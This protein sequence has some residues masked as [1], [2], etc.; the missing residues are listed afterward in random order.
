MKVCPAC[1]EENPE[2]ARFCLNCGTALQ[3]AA[4]R[5]REERKVVTVLFADLVD[6][7]RARGAPRPGGRPRHAP[8]L[9]RP[10]SRRARAVRRHCREVHR[11]C[12]GRL[13]DIA[14]LVSHVSFPSSFLDLLTAL[15][16][17]DLVAAADRLGEAGWRSEEALV[18]LR[19]GERLPAAGRRPEAEAQ[20]ARA[21]DF[22]R[23]VRATA[24]LARGERLLARSA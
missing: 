19:A 5:G 20:L 7:H 6:F 23:S 10:G 17:G 24:Y 3:E 18:R 1:G 22:F 21:L 15:A 2:R 4:P 8:G 11:R 16:S 9:P 12:L 13:D 14:E